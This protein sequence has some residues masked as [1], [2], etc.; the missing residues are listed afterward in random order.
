MNSRRR[1]EHADE[2]SVREVGWF[3][4]K[5]KSDEKSV[6]EGGWYEKQKYTVYRTNGIPIEGSR[7]KK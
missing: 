7:T 1:K 2:G 4:E 3:D 6:Q 5:G